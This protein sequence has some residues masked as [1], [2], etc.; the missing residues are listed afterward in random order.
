MKVVNRAFIPPFAIELAYRR[1]IMKLIRDMVK[2]YRVLFSIYREKK[3]QVAMDAGEGTWLTTEVQKR[4]KSLGSKWEKRFKEFAENKSPDMVKKVLKNTDLQLKSILKDYFA[5]VRFE[6]LDMPVALKQV[7]NAHIA[8]NVSLIKSIAP[9]YLDRVQ[10]ALS[11]AITGGGSIRQFEMEVAKYSGQELNRAKLIAHDQIHKVFTTMVARRCGQLGV[12]R[13]QWF[14][15]H[16]RKEPRPYHIRKWDGKSGLKDGHPNGL[17]GFI[18]ELGNLPVIQ[19]ET[20]S[21]SGKVQKEIRGLPSQLV[22]CG[23]FMK[24]VIE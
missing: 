8:E 18:F 12:K 10:G 21:K 13:M 4:L 11:R 9:Q 19:E 24:P 16:A 2:D 14:H 15:S 5:D 23:C 22:N 1:A 17:D 6:L 20:V 7:V 3:S